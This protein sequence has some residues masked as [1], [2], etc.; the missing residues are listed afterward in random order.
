MQSASVRFS[1]NNLSKDHLTPVT[2]T[3]SSMQTEFRKRIAI[4]EDDVNQA[5][6]LTA[7][8]EKAGYDTATCAD[9]DRFLDLIEQQPFDMLLLDWDVPG[10]SGINVLQRT[11]ERIAHAMPIVLVTQHDEEADVVY[12]LEHGADDYL[13]KPVTENI[14]IARVGAQLRRYYP[15]AP[16]EPVIKAGDYELRGSRVI[17]LCSQSIDLPER[18]FRLAQLLFSN[19][20]RIVTKKALIQKIWSADSDAKLEESAKGN[21]SQ[22]AMLSTYISKLRTLLQLGARHGVVITAIYGY[23]YRLEQIRGQGSDEKYTA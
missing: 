21:R 3:G 12:G 16:A 7:W 20:G 13:V 11:R 17:M 10:A 2:V 9:G 14:L 6:T 8:L 22:E 15:A 5:R 18:E 19:L 1:N 4:L 23:G